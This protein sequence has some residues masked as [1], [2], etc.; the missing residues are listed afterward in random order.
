MTPHVIFDVD[1]TLVASEREG[2]RVAF[3]AA[4]EQLGMPDRWGE[5]QYGALLSVAGGRRRLRHYLIEQGREEDE[6]TELA[7]RLH[8]IKTER[9]RGM[10]VDG[11]IPVRPGARR[12]LDEL[13]D[14]GVT[15]A[16]ATTGSR[17]WVEPL[18]DH[19][20]GLE[21]FVA[22]LTGDDVERRKPDPEVYARALRTLGAEASAVV[23]VEDA[24]KGVTAAGDVG[25]ACVVVVNDYT[26]HEFT[27][28]AGGD[29]R[30]PVLVVDRFGRPGRASVL[31]GPPGL[32]DDGAVT[33]ATL[34]GLVG[35]RGDGA[36]D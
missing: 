4:F 25:I 28:G 29:G 9:F 22:V 5:E 8:E 19:L 36:A 30:P 33:L 14:A 3:N 32:L 6:A 7:A 13:A 26:R 12:L 10:A 11:R 24:A 17:A 15:V 1:G 31:H 23:A 2:H 27:D 20:F 34:T 35:G 21:R 16:V 18:L